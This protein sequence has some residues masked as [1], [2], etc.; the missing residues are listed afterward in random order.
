MRP[1]LLFLSLS[2]SVSV[3]MH[4]SL[5]FDDERCNRIG[6]NSGF[7]HAQQHRPLASFVWIRSRSFVPCA[8]TRRSEESCAPFSNNETII[9]VAVRHRVELLFRLRRPFLFLRPLLVS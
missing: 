2:I 9:T 8:S 1:N 5:F 3:G 7:D 6:S 4:A